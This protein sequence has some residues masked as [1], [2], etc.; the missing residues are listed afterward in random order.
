MKSCRPN[1]RVQRTRLRSP[2]T[3][4]PLGGGSIMVA[5]VAAMAL[6]IMGM[7]S[8]SAIVWTK[9]GE[10]RM[11]VVDRDGKPIP[12]V[13]V[14]LKATT[15]GS[16]HRTMISDTK[17][18]AAFGGVSPGAYILTFEL[19]GFAPSSIGPITMR[20]EEREN[21]QL[22]EFLVTMNPVRWAG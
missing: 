22:P 4:H 20:G 1:K 3:R 19:S 6:L 8:G 11:V 18:R 21:P 9:P 2:L 14:E 13:S 10:L 7:S 12:G 5:R 15:D 16:P 17:G